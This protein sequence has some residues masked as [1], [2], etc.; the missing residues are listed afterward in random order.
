MDLL[1]LTAVIGVLLIAALAMIGGVVALLKQKVVVD[2][3][4]QVTGIELPLLGKFNTNYPSLVAV[5]IGAALAYGVYHKVT[6]VPDS[7]VT[8]ARVDVEP[9]GVRTKPQVFVVI[10]Q[11]YHLVKTDVTPGETTTIPVTVRKA[12]NY[13]VIVYTVAGIDADGNAIKSEDDGAVDSNGQFN[14]N[15]RLK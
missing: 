11:E 1:P 15:L 4:G 10:P 13:H 2:Q 8:N 7:M 12:S 5:A 9:A 6:I 14:G 3:S